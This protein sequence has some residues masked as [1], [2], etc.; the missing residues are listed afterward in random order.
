MK[1]I[2]NSLAALRSFVHHS[3]DLGEKYSRDQ[4]RQVIRP[5]CLC[6]VEAI[7]VVND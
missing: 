5:E 2:L 3:R 7:A 1:N 6:E 4:I